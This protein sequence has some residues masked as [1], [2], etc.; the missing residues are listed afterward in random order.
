MIPFAKCRSRARQFRHAHSGATAIEFAILVPPLIFASLFAIDLGNTY[1]IASSL[2]GA[3]AALTEEIRSGEAATLTQG[4]FCTRLGLAY[5]DAERLGVNVAPLTVQGAPPPPAPGS[6]AINLPTG[7]GAT[8]A[9]LVYRVSKVAPGL[10]RDDLILRA[11]GF[12]SAQ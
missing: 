4:N 11:G 8:I 10:E 12:T 1:M 7:G 3:S 2:D 9:T 5:C 6:F